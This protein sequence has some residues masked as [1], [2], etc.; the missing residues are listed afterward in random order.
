MMKSH[1]KSSVFSITA[2]PSRPH[3][4]GALWQ[5]M[6]GSRV[7]NACLVQKEAPCEEQT[8]GQLACR[9]AMRFLTGRRQEFVP[10]RRVP[11]V[12]VNNCAPLL[13]RKVGPFVFVEAWRVFKTCRVLGRLD[14]RKKSGLEAGSGDFFENQMFVHVEHLLSVLLDGNKDGNYERGKERSPPWFRERPQ[15]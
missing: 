11:V 4:M 14:F 1:H 5:R 9:F 7:W 8:Q 3:R 15:F 10:I 12:F 2:S 6:S 13:V